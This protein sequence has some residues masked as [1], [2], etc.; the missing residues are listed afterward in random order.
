MKIIWAII[1]LGITNFTQAQNDLV[2][3]TYD[4]AGN[5]TQRI[6]CINCLS[7][8]KTNDSIK[9]VSVLQKE[10][11][12]KFTPDD[13]ISYY[14]NPVKEELYLQWNFIEGTQ[15]SSISVYDM[16]GRL[17]KYLNDMSKV[18]N[19]NISFLNY[20]RGVYAVVLSYNNGEQK[21]IKIIKE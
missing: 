20:S 2:K 6:L 11:L 4:S 17:L 7:A 15:I 19:Q 5:Q 1:F 12:Q 13:D 14:P 3:F 9:E 21:S 8:K 10:D 18:N 16:N